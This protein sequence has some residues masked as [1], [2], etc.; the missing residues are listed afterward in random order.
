MTF[1]FNV[2]VSPPKALDDVLGFES[3]APLA[4]SPAGAE[5]YHILQH[6]T[7]LYCILPH[8]IYLVLSY[9]ILSYI[10]LSY[11]IYEGTAAGP[12]GVAAALLADGS[13]TAALLQAPFKQRNIS[14]EG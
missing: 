8:G 3:D 11:L 6:N 5:E 7:T 12:H 9:L 1:V 14:P 4:E 13:F 10:I 2:D